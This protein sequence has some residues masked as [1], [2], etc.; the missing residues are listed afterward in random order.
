VRST[1]A[2]TGWQS[3]GRIWRAELDFNWTC[4]KISQKSKNLRQKSHNEAP[5]LR[6]SYL[7]SGIIADFGDN[8]INGIV[9]FGAQFWRSARQ[10]F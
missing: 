5:A 8:A 4:P 3:R 10:T 1:F 6:D 2:A 9:A 7:S